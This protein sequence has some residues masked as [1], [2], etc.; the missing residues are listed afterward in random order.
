MKRGKFRRAAIGAALAL[1]ATVILGVQLFLTADP[2]VPSVKALCD[3]ALRASQSLA[4]PPV[5][6][7]GRPLSAATAARMKADGEAT[8]R[9]LYTGPVLARQISELDAFIAEQL[10]GA[11]VVRDAGVSK[12]DCDDVAV[13]GDTATVKAEVEIWTKLGQVQEDGSVI[14]ARPKNV[15]EYVFT[16]V[17]VDGRWLIDGEH[18]EFKPGFGP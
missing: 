1:V 16:M 17:K 13:S 7:R 15:Q 11:F 18:W 4:V 14:A 10:G 8:L 3:R 6:D 12:A 5:A 9:D 2:D